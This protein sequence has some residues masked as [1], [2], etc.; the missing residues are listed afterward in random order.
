MSNNKTHGS[1]YNSGVL[2]DSI[3]ADYQIY[4]PKNERTVVSDTINASTN[5]AEYFSEDSEQVNCEIHHLNSAMK[6]EFGLLENTRL[7]IAV[8]ENGILINLSNS[9]YNHV[10]DIVT[11]GGAFLPGK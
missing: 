11:P 10:S 6:Y 7:A 9:K 5:M 2:E 8:D 1:E 4:F 3:K